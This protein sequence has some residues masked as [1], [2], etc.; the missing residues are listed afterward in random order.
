M[1]DGVA[2]LV[3][4]Q[5]REPQTRG[6]NIRQG[7]K[8]AISEF[9]RVKNVVLT[10]CLCKGTL[11]ESDKNGDGRYLLTLSD[12]KNKQTQQ[13]KTMSDSRGQTGNNTNT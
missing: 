11:H 12:S 6:S 13:Q 4:R 8:K 5:T 10:R 9:F 2:Q 3:E 1:G 7:H